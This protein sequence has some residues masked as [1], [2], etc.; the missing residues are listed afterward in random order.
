M[1]CLLRE[2]ETTV[3]ISSH[4]LTDL[5]R[6][7]DT[8]ILVDSGRVLRNCSLDDF[9]EEYLKVRITTNTSPNFELPERLILR[10]LHR[11]SSSALLLIRKDAWDELNSLTSATDVTTETEVPLLEEA[12]R[13]TI[14]LSKSNR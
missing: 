14:E 4:V 7:V 5:E 8:I 12:F 13:H 2:S 6:T 1:L 3:V 10:T 11:D 9:R